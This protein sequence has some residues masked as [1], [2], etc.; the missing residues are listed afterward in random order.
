MGFARTWTEELVG[1][2]LTL[3]GYQVTTGVPV[4]SGVSKITGRKVGGRLEADIVGA[5]VLGSTLE[6]Q[7]I[8]VGVLADNMDNNIKR[9]QEKFTPA[10]QQGVRKFLE[11]SFGSALSW[12][13]R[14]RYI[15][16][17]V[18]QRQLNELPSRLS[19][20]RLQAFDDFI[21]QDVL[22]TLSP[23]VLWVKTVPEG[24]WLLG[25]LSYLQAKKML[26]QAG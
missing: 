11:Q 12:D 9:I 3:K 1:E 2:W 22:P 21:L 8:E 13:Y 20:I 19:D 15:A 26:A 17:Y 23:Y 14:C 4:G 5:K 16:V 10:R 6:V 25:M 24:L 18:S 7:H